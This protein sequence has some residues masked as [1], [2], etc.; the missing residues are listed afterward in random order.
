MPHKSVYG[1]DY[2]GEVGPTIVSKVSYA[3]HECIYGWDYVGEVGPTIVSKVSYATHECIYGWDYVGEVGPTIV[4]KVSYATH[5][6]IYGWDYVGEVGPTIVSKV[7]FTASNFSC[8]FII[9]MCSVWFKHHCYSFQDKKHTQLFRSLGLLKDSCSV[10]LRYT[11][12]PFPH[13]SPYLTCDDKV[14]KKLDNCYL[15]LQLVKK[16]III[17][18][19]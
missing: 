17:K 9:R 18:N 13:P 10:V 15:K 12:H 5:E 7:S 11:L 8:F 3:T 2:V 6:C 1:W 14:Y 16:V 4:S 19:L